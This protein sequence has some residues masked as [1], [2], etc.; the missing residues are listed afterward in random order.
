MSQGNAPW[1]GGGPDRDWQL[2]FLTGGLALRSIDGKE[3]R[4]ELVSDSAA[5]RSIRPADHRQPGP[6]EPIVAAVS[7]DCYAA[8]S[9]GSP[10]VADQSSVAGLVHR[11]WRQ[12]PN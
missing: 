3:S 7:Q 5:A 2:L 1:D 9:Q 8:L 12:A 4:A 10:T 11:Y 6:S